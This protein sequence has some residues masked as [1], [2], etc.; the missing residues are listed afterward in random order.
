[1]AMCEALSKILVLAEYLQTRCGVPKFVASEISEIEQAAKAALAAPPRNC[2]V[3]TPEEQT[4]RMDAF[5]ASHGEHIGQSWRCEKCPLF[6]IN[7]CELAW[8]QMPYD[9]K[10]GG[11]K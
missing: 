11:T 2:D 10:E 8:A 3:G 6:T 5:C 9:E 7:R 1:M 4:K